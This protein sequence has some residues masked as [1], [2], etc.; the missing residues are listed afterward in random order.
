[1]KFLNLLKLYYIHTSYILQDS[2]QGYGSA[3][4]V[5]NLWKGI[6]IRRRIKK[7]RAEMCFQSSDL[8]YATGKVKI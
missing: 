8:L 7:T 1:L 3:N 6:W 4:N 5:Q 2:F